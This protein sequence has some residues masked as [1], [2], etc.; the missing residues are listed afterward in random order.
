M[1]PYGFGQSARAL[2]GQIGRGLLRA[3]RTLAEAAM[4][5]FEPARQIGGGLREAATEFGAGLVGLPG[6]EDMER[7]I[8][9][10]FRAPDSIAQATL[11]P[12]RPPA[13][14]TAIEEALPNFD[15]VESGASSDDGIASVLARD[16]RFRDVRGGGS[17]SAPGARTLAEAP[18]D[19]PG[20]IRYAI[21]G[22]PTKEYGAGD[23]APLA[24]G[25][26]RAFDPVDRRVESYQP[27]A[28]GGTV[29]MMTA[30][31][32]EGIVTA[33]SRLEDAQNERAI[34]EA[35]GEPS[36]AQIFAARQAQERQFGPKEQMEYSRAEA[37]SKELQALNVLSQRLQQAVAA[38]QMS[39]EMADAQFEKERESAAFRLQALQGDTLAAWGPKPNPY[40]MGGAPPVPG[41]G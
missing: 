31:E 12:P 23:R 14:R 40:E 39:A 32:N 13:P 37:T 15:D 20:S 28:G 1:D 35:R 21:G 19:E 7:Q 26:G 41:R 9:E 2:P 8:G 25:A 24:P 30:P 22:G 5:P 4:L 11:P 6:R 16:P 17:S 10:A 27:A 38:G 18:R 33:A 36:L 34:A 29:S 3:P